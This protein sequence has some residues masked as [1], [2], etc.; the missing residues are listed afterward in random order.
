M[1]LLSRG[2]FEQKERGEDEYKKEQAVFDR[3]L[4]VSIGIQDR[5]EV[6]AES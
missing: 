1:N 6:R 4:D 2:H 3:A 5:Q